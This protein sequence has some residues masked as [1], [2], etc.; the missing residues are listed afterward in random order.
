M[1]GGVLAA[2]AAI[3]L[4]VTAFGGSSS[5]NVAS[6]STVVRTASSAAK[7]S[8]SHRHTPAKTAAPANA[9][10]TSVVVLNGTETTGLAHRI[11]G[12]LQRSGYSQAAPLSGRP[13]G[14]NQ[15][16]VV[17]YAGGHRSDAESVANSL[18]VSQVQPI[19]TPV[20]TL[21]GSASVVVI[22][23]ADKAAAGP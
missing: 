5:S 18:G 15:V 2:G 6:T 11:S 7:H 20:A 1:I 4:A 8:S 13:P 14:N 21:A 12:E 19:E 10:E 9:A 3:V 17:E 22:V 23:G 16:T